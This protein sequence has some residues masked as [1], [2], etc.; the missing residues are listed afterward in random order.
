MSHH[1]EIYPTPDARCARCGYT[2]HLIEGDGETV[3]LECVDLL[4]GV[5]VDPFSASPELRRAMVQ[6]HGDIVKLGEEDS[7]AQAWEWTAGWPGGDS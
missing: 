2:R 1:T 5:A 3:C 6:E 4:T 7:G